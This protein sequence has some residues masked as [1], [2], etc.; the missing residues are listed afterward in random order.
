V[1]AACPQGRSHMERHCRPLRDTLPAGVRVSAAGPDCTLDL[2]GRSSSP[3]QA[4]VTAPP[5]TSTTTNKV[6]HVV[7]YHISACSIYSCV[8]YTLHRQCL[9]MSHVDAFVDGHHNTS[10]S[11]PIPLLSFAIDERGGARLRGCR[12]HSQKSD[13]F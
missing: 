11:L 5:T 8:T 10:L 3:G 9:H 12:R 1:A 13:K 6:L 4:S 7:T 2:E